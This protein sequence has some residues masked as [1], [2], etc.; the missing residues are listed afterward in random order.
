MILE[1]ISCRGIGVDV[2]FMVDFGVVICRY[3]KL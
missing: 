3:L 2:Y 1:V